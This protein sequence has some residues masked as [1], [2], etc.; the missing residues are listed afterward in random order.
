MHS[1]YGVFLQRQCNNNSIL[2]HCYVVRSK[3]S[4]YCH[5]PSQEAHSVPTITRF[6]RLSKIERRHH[7]RKIPQ[8]CHIR[9][10]CRPGNRKPGSLYFVTL[11]EDKAI[12]NAAKVS[13]K[14][15]CK[16]GR[17]TRRAP[18]TAINCTRRKNHR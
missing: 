7:Y 3:C 13:G 12:A 17:F 15:V 16:M 2:S 1:N 14:R 18:E 4:E 10:L 6:P 8:F 11:T 5:I 9:R